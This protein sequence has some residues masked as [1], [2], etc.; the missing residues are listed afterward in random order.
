MWA[1]PCKLIHLLLFCRTSQGEASLGAERTGCK[2]LHSKRDVRGSHNDHRWSRE[3]ALP[4]HSA[5]GPLVQHDTAK[6]TLAI[7]VNLSQQASAPRSAVDYCRL[8]ASL[9]RGDAIA[10][11]YPSRECSTELPDNRSAEHSWSTSEVSSGAG[12]GTE[13]RLLEKTIEE[14]RQLCEKLQHPHGSTR[15]AD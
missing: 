4:S 2:T 12:T 5:I 9:H 13:D 8:P 11:S 1:D 14:W 15:F 7:A 6:S 10:A 3:F